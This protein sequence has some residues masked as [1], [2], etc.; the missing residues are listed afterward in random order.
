MSEGGSRPDAAVQAAPGPPRDPSHAGRPFRTTPRP[1][2]SADD[3]PARRRGPGLAG[4]LMVVLPLAV[5]LAF[6]VG[7]AEGS[8][9]VLGPLTTFALPVAAVI[10]FWWENWP[11]TRL[12]APW[13]GWADTALIAA[14]GVAL[15]LA[16][17]AATARPDPAGVFDP[18]AGAAHAAT[19]PA[20]MPLAGAA[21][22]AMLHLTLACERWP[23]SR[24][25]RR[26]AGL[27]ALV[28]TWTAALAVVSAMVEVSVPVAGA[29]AHAGLIGGAEFGAL[30]VVAGTWETL[31]F[32]VLRGRPL[33]LIGSRA[34]RLTANNAAV[35]AGT[36]L[37]YLLLSAGLG[38]AA[39]T[40]SAVCGCVIAGGLLA[41]MLFE[42]RPGRAGQAGVLALVAAV[43]T[44][45]FVL[46]TG[47]AGTQPWER[48]TAA[49]WVAYVALNAIGLSVILHVG[50]GR[51]WPFHDTSALGKGTS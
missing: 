8:V 17:Q 19:F 21:F 14:G 12:R 42:A 22:T 34:W 37:T 16:G 38:L 32:V 27:I 7:G 50:I 51:R 33:N 20:T 35:L 10:A 18:G 4:G 48:A 3:R 9:L 47:L 28:A 25:D 26:L 44:A 1:S 39:N 5:L 30:T 45:L 23:L 41:G 31:L 36:A 15:T 29:R 40:I 13:S 46:L 2:G 43:S 11:G 49:D 24:L 6:G